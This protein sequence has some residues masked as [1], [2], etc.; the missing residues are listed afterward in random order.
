MN[1][2]TTRHLAL[3]TDL[4]A[5]PTE[6]SWFE[7]KANNTDPQLIGKLAS[8]LANSARIA[9]EDFGYLIWGVADTD[10]AIVGTNFDPD[11]TKKGNEPL[12][13]WLA[14][15]LKPSPAFEFIELQ[16]PLG[17]VVMLA[18]P[19]A[20]TAPVR[21][22]NHAYIRIGEATSSLAEFP[23]RES[24]LWSKLRPTMWERGIAVQFIT[25]SDVLE[26]IDYPEYFHRTSQPLPDNRAGIL[27]RLSED[28]VILRDAGDNWSISNLGALLFARRLDQFDRIGRKAPRVIQYEGCN[29]VVTM[30]EQIGVKGYA[31]GFE[32]MVA[33]IE[34]LLPHNEHIGQALRV[35]RPMYPGIAIRELVANALIHQDFTVS[36]AGPMVE[37]FAN[38]VEITNPGAPLIE[39]NRFIGSPPHSRNEDLA[40]LMR[41][42]HICE[43]RGTGVVKALTAIELFQLPPVDFQVFQGSLR[44]VIH[45]PLKLADMNM[46]ERVRA[47]YQHAS[48][49]WVGGERLTNPSFRQRLGVDDDGRWL[50][51]RIIKAAVDAEQIR[52]ADPENPRAGYLPWWA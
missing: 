17:R 32:R 8:A 41:R 38:R 43:E 42:M 49:R 45:A 9:N 7:F 51:S 10:H 47:C 11:T 3:L 40:S 19:A 25:S 26:L 20:T 12:P 22:D 44:A 52:P 39:V 21:F 18:I 46:V 16:H 37:L 15:H 29:R 1:L 34:N 33:F 6:A 2:Q 27:A 13:I 35:E 31:A 5:R 50:I 14:T 30:R 48:L 28:R 4:R 23:D 24:E 36:G